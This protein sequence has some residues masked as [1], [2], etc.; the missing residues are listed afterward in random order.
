MCY[1][2]KLIANFITKEFKQQM[3]YIIQQ[4]VD[5][6]TGEVLKLERVNKDPVYREDCVWIEI[7]C[8]IKKSETDTYLLEERMLVDEMAIKFNTVLGDSGFYYTT[9]KREIEFEVPKQHLKDAKAYVKK[10]GYAV[11]IIG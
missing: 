2:L 9:G 10:M 4:I 7:T 6:T 11:S 1:K 8:K 5:N 3:T